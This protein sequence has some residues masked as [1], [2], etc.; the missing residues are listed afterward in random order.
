M[1]VRAY[2]CCA[3]VYENKSIYLPTPNMNL[4]AMLDLHVYKEKRMPYL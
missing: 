2:K 3:W 1:R 4:S